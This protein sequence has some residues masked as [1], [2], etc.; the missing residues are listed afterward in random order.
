MEVNSD[1]PIKSI[2]IHFHRCYKFVLLVINF[3]LKRSTVY[4]P[5]VNSSLLRLDHG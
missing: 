3:V 2:R 4:V 5:I 1:H